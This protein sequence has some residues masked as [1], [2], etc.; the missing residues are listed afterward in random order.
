M[1]RSLKNKNHTSHLPDNL[2]Y[3]IW[4]TGLPGSGKT[5]IGSSL[6][7]EFQS[8]DIRSELL[9]GDEIRKIISSE[10]GFSK[11]D[12]DT[13]LRRVTYLCQ[14]L[15]R[16]GIVAIVALISPYKESRQY[17]RSKI[18]NFVEV[19]VKCPLNVCIERDPKGLY[20]RATDGKINSLTGVQD[21]YENPLNPE[22][23]LN[24]DCETLNIS[25]NKVLSYFENIE[26]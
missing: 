22:I 12:R 13:H 16:N 2:S 4:L 19:W 21:P 23:I 11:N 8:R 3:T 7:K 6:V 26:K 5:T 25:T 9:D 15:N 24:T 1:S 20:K 14:L 10:L 18:K 17:A